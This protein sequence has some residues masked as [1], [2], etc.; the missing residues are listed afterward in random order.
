MRSRGAARYLSN[1]ELDVIP[2]QVDHEIFVN[3]C[4][5]IGRDAFPEACTDA[6]GVDRAA[7]HQTIGDAAVR[8]FD[9]ALHVT[10][11]D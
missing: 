5:K 10:R 1:A 8:F 11:P 6:P 9:D 2:G 4:N 7:I 3:G